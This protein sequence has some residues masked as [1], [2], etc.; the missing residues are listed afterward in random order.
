M[1]LVAAAFG[2]LL[3]LALLTWLLLRGID[4]NVRTYAATLQTF[5]DF[6]LAEASLQRD[7]LQAR[8]GLLRDYDPLGS[9]EDAMEDAL[10]RLRSYARSSA[11]STEPIDRLGEAIAQQE[12]LTERFKSSNSVFQNSLAYVGLTSTGPTFGSKDTELA[13]AT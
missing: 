6:A 8:A 13:P 10:A 11:L 12:E 4:T 1:R 3:L 5:D 9:A 7:V 2:V